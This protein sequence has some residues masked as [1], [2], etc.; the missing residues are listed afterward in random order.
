MNKRLRFFPL[1]VDADIPDAQHCRAYLY[2]EGLGVPRDYEQARCGF[3]QRQSGGNVICIVCE[4]GSRA[5]PSLVAFFPQPFL[6]GSISR[7]PS[8]RL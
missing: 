5:H 2:F 4:A 6:F 1:D 3:E 8:C 7:R